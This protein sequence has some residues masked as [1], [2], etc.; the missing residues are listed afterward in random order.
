MNKSLDIVFLV[1]ISSG[2]HPILKALQQNIDTFIDAMESSYNY[3]GYVITGVKDWRIKVC[4]Y[5]KCDGGVW[6]EE[7]PFTA[8]AAQVHADFDSLESRSGGD[9]PES[10]LDALWKLSNMPDAPEPG[11]QADCNTWRHKRDAGRSVVVFTKARFHMVTSLPE[12]GGATFDDVARAVM[13]NKLRL[14]VY[15]PEMDCYHRLSE[16]D[17]IEIEF[18]GTLADAEE[19]MREYSKPENFDTTMKQLGKHMTMIFPRYWPYDQL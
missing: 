14:S 9:E 7:K 6:W 1:D 2:M 16:I 12:A 15:C 3:D 11:D 19:K 18:V 4:G 5:T 8:D 10:L 13:Q 17:G